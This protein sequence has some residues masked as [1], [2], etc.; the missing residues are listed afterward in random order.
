MRISPLGAVI[1]LN[2]DLVIELRKVRN[3]VHAFSVGWLNKKVMACDVLPLGC[4]VEVSTLKPCSVVLSHSSASFTV[5]SVQKAANVPERGE[6]PYCPMSTP[7]IVHRVVF[8]LVSSS[9]VHVPWACH[10][11][12]M[13]KEMARLHTLLVIVLVMPVTLSVSAKGA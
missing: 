5:P 9:G 1:C 13:L 10:G 8:L 11:S 4:T 12:S 7:S 3:I 2:P 6:K